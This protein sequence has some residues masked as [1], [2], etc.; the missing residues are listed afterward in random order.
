MQEIRHAVHPKAIFA[1]RLG[2]RSIE[3]RVVRAAL[4]MG[5]IA[6]VLLM[7]GTLVLAGLGLE[8]ETAFS[9]CMTAMFNSGPG[10][11]ELGPTGNFAQVPDLGKLLLS[12]YMVAGRLEFYTLLALLL[13]GFWKGP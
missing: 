5:V 10:L 12:F 7:V 8:V 6:T 3:D 4:A 2:G 9:A 1:T 11:N 13:P